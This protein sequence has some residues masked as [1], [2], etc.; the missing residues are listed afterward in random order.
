MT[1][2]P[3][4]DQPGSRIFAD[5]TKRETILYGFGELTDQMSHQAFQFLVFTFYYAVVGIDV[6]PLAVGLFNSSVI[7]RQSRTR[8]G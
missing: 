7:D 5:P 4:P 3:I 2:Q 6:I 1:E 8:H